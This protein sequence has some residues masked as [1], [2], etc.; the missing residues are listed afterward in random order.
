ME[1]KNIFSSKGESAEEITSA[2]HEWYLS[3]PKFSREARTPFASIIKAIKNEKDAQVLLFTSIPD[4][5]SEGVCSLETAR[6]IRIVKETYDG[7]LGNLSD[8]LSFEVKEIFSQ[9]SYSLWLSS[10]PESSLNHLFTDG[11]ERLFA[12]LKKNSASDDDLIPDLA[13][14]ATGLRL[15]DWE[16]STKEKFI[17]QIKTWKKSA[18]NFSLQSDSEKTT[19]NENPNTTKSYAVSFPKEDGKVMTK[20]FEKV[21]ESPRARLLF[22][23]VTDALDTMGQSLNQ[24]EKRQV[25]MRVLET[26]CG[27]ED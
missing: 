16:E 27:G 3:L 4:A 23:K 14:A 19:L 2:I 13:F 6:K 9:S 20:Y 22:N 15:E 24:A 7:L 10:L 12:V 8:E 26:L 5:L 21:N 11:T 1:L 17:S 25:L 18:E